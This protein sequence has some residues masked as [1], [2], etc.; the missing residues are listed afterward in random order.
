MDMEDRR[1]FNDFVRLAIEGAKILMRVAHNI[2][3][4]ITQ[5]QVL[6]NNGQVL[7]GLTFE[8]DGTKVSP[9]VYVNDAFLRFKEGEDIDS[10][11][12]GLVETAYQ[13][14]EHNIEI[15]EITPE[16]IKEHV[17][18]AVV[19]A[20][21]NEE[22]LSDTPHYLL[23][24]GMLAAYPRYHLSDE[25][26]FRVT[27]QMCISE[28][29]KMT[30]DEVLAVAKANT[31]SLDYKVATIGD[32][33]RGIYNGS[34][35]E[36]DAMMEEANP[37]M[38]VITTMDG[39]NGAAAIL[40]NTAMERAREMLGCDSIFVLPSSVSEVIAVPDNGDTDPKVLAAMIT[41]INE[42]Q[43]RPEEV[44]A[45]V[46]FRYDGHKIALAIDTPTMKVDAD[47]GMKIEKHM[48]MAMA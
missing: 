32:M 28:T 20:A 9:T 1:E 30:P 25:A 12:R 22:L 39:V 10:I 38:I 42:T 21:A 3:C 48:T 36:F 4:E 2:E 16:S 35:E 13:G 14:M 24:D 18:L 7:D 8:R 43:L 47:D 44:L 19:N 6:K 37:Q 45:D 31:E 33:L 29:V 17:R 46:P 34:T 26:S 41:E 23:C 15:P 27:T 40:S 11:V 5:R